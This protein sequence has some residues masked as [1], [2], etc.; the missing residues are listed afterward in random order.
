MRFSRAL[1]GRLENVETYVT[2]EVAVERV[3]RGG[4]DVVASGTHRIAT[5][6]RASDDQQEDRMA[7]ERAD[8]DDLGDIRVGE[9]LDSLFRHAR[10]YDRLLNGTKLSG[11]DRKKFGQILRDVNK[12]LAR[13][14]EKDTDE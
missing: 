7:T 11:N 6:S 13:G 2:A 8:Q 12:S 4:V 9:E 1:G 3:A 10:E 14:L 5:V